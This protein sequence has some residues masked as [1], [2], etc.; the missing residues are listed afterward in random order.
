MGV[1]KRRWHFTEEHLHIQLYWEF[2]PALPSLHIRALVHVLPA[3][4][5]NSSLLKFVCVNQA[6]FFFF[7]FNHLIPSL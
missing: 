6:N 3:F 7:F 5:N 1:S 4:V 2:S